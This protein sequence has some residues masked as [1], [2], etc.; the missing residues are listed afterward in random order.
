MECSSDVDNLP[1]A[2]FMQCVPLPL[3]GAGAFRY[4]DF[5]FVLV[6]W[7]DVPPEW[8]IGIGSTVA[9]LVPDFGATRTYAKWF[10]ETN[11]DKRIT[12]SVDGGYERA[13][14][15]DAAVECMRALKS[16]GRPTLRFAQVW[17]R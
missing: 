10:W 11:L 14:G 4:V 12:C 7:T 2:E 6:P 16:D 17:H 9:I 3:A 15:V 1:A 13:Y 5:P 8:R